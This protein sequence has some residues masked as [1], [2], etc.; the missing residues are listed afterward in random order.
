MIHFNKSFKEAE[1]LL[2]EIGGPEAGHSMLKA[3]LATPG[4]SMKIFGATPSI[5]ILVCNASVYEPRSFFDET[6]EEISRHF[7]I[8]FLSNLSLVRQFAEQKIRFGSIIIVLDERIARTSP[9]EGSYEMSKKMLAELTLVAA[10]KLA[11]RIRVNAVAPGAVIPP[12]TLKNSTMKQH[13]AKMPLR[14]APL[15]SDVADA[16]IF[17]VKNDSITGQFIFIDGGEHLNG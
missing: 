1:K 15:P 8:N 3:D 17:L 4:A 10:K 7:N 2:S 16:C 5:D 14:R 9:D 12:R 13:I 6:Q 11:P